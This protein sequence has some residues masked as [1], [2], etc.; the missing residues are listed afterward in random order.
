DQLGEEEGSLR[1]DH[2]ALVHDVADD[3]IA[4]S[5][6]QWYEEQEADLFNNEMSSSFHRSKNINMIV[7][8]LKRWE[9]DL[10]NTC[11]TQQNRIQ[12]VCLAFKR[13]DINQRKGDCF[14]EPF[15]SRPARGSNHLDFEIFNEPIK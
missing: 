4:K 11:Q 14:G 1:A 8:I 9:D 6:E 15:L 13:K 5:H 12:S 7:F 3:L 10:L 2:R